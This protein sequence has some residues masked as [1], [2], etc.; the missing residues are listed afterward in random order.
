MSPSQTYVAQRRLRRARGLLGIVWEVWYISENVR[1]VAAEE[2]PDKQAAWE[3]D[4]LGEPRAGSEGSGH[5]QPRVLSSGGMPVG[6]SKTRE[7]IT[8]DRKQL[9]RMDCE[10]T[11]PVVGQ[12]TFSEV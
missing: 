9:G 5:C 4:S 8:R 7:T 3:Y 12:G 10:H 11:R 1:E 6:D 2:F